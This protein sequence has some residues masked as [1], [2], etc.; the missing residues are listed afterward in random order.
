MRVCMHGVL[1][2]LM[3]MFADF[4]SVAN[5]LLRHVGPCSTTHKRPSNSCSGTQISSVR[6]ILL[7]TGQ[8]C[9]LASNMF[10]KMS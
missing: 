2:L 9:T 4:I 3:T 7:K 10:L 8:N 6:Y 5:K 1:P